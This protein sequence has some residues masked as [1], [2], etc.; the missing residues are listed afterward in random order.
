MKRT[1][2]SFSTGPGAAEALVHAANLLESTAPCYPVQSIVIR[3]ITAE[4]FRMNIASDSAAAQQ[5]RNDYANRLSQANNSNVVLKNQPATLLDDAAYSLHHQ[6]RTY[7]F[8]AV[9]QSRNSHPSKAPEVRLGVSEIIEIL[10]DEALNEVRAVSIDCLGQNGV[11]AAVSLGIDCTKDISAFTEQ[12][13]R[14]LEARQGLYIA[15]VPLEHG[16]L[17]VTQSRSIIRS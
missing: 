6:N 7:S 8:R 2:P 4:L 12:N 5:L 3:A 15:S 13:P 10:D 11:S 16:R 17:Q 14:N 1:P 9:A